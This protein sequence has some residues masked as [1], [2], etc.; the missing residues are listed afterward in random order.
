MKLGEILVSAGVIDQF[1]L[2]SA[3][4][5]QQ[6]WG[7]RLGITLIKLGFLD[8]RDL[9]QAL[10]GQLGLPVAHLEGKRIQSEI[11][12]LVPVE[13]AER[14]MCIPLFLREEHGRKTLFL[15]MEDPCDLQVMDELA[16]RT[17]MAVRP[18]LMGPSEICEGI[19]R[20]YHRRDRGSEALELTES[21]APAVLARAHR[22]PDPPASVASPGLPGV[23]ANPVAWI[24]AIAEILVE[25][26]V[27]T[28]ED[29]ESRVRARLG[30]SDSDPTGVS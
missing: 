1:Q 3:L 25:S 28:R 10:A 24:E 18:V 6:R 2:R 16:F 17:G 26:G 23:A 19:D 29:L 21:P 11:L 27:V 20:F 22:E 15:G 30:R 13:V 5:E 8:E 12:D 14:S 4:G 9:V 7:G